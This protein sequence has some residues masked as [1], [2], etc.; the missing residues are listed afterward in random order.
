MLN[1]EKCIWQSSEVCLSNQD[2]ISMRYS[3]IDELKK[4]ADQNFRRRVRFCSHSSASEPVH[5]MV[6]VHPQYAYVRPHKHLGK[7]ESMLVMEGEVDYIIF[8]D[9]GNLKN[10]VSM[11]DYRS[12]KPFYQSIRT[13]LYHTLIIHSPW[14]VFLE[15]TKGPFLREDT[16]FAPWSPDDSDS[17]SI[18]AFLNRYKEIKI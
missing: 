13:D 15:T 10:L 7:S 9:T 18:K 1:L 6:I 12:G 5:E 2:I 11:G 14:L 4:I 17:S 16:I 3:N 8:D